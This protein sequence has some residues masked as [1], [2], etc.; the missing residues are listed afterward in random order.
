MLK[1]ATSLKSHATF[2]DGQDHPSD[3]FLR[4]H[5]QC[6]LATSASAGNATEDY[7]D[8]EV[9]LFMEELG[10]YDNEMDTSDPRWSTP[11]GIEVYAYLVRQRMRE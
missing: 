2:V 3:Q 8:Q 5:F 7:R 11:L 10:V 6:C 9:D 1:G 4:L